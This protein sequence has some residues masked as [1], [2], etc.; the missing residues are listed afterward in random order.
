MEAHGA[1]TVTA[2][3][4]VEA[5]REQIF[6]FLSDLDRHW[7]LGGRFVRVVE[8][9][10]PEGARNG[11][12]VRLR[13]PLGLSR[14]VRTR[15]LETEMPSRMTGSAE[16]GASTAAT[17]SW[18]LTPIGDGETHVVL[19]AEVV[20]AG[21][22]DRVLLALGGLRWLERMFDSTLSTLAARFSRGRHEPVAP[23]PRRDA[24]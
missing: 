2:E 11:G 18:A 19:R 7:L 16:I 5:P 3:R 10:G 23:P 4:T 1:P 15:V 13:G 17:V 24:G 21:R 8:L 6:E 14:K 9:D 20:R 22:L 12:V